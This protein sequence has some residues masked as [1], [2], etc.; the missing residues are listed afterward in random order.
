VVD[1]GFEKSYNLMDKETIVGEAFVKNGWTLVF[2]VKEVTL[3]NRWT[4]AL[5]VKELFGE[6]TYN[7]IKRSIN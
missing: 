6:N 4:G 7:K 2:K 3:I 1:L 5:A